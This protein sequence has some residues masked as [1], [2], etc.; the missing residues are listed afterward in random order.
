MSAR[1]TLLAAIHA[2]LPR[3]LTLADRAALSPNAGSADRGYWH[4]RVDKDYPSATFAQI[5]WPLALL[6]ERS[7]LGL[8]TAVRDRLRRVALDAISWW[9]VIQHRDGSF[10]EWFRFERSQVAT[11]FT[12]FAV[13]EAAWILREPLATWPNRARLF[14]ALARSCHWLA[15]HPDRAVANHAAGAVAAL[16]SVARLIPDSAIARSELDALLPLQTDEGWFPEYGGADPGYATVSLAFLA[17]AQRH[18]A[19][20]RLAASITKLADFCAPFV[21]P[22]GSFGGVYGRRA[23]RYAWLQGFALLAQKSPSARATL[24]RLLS[25]LAHG[26]LPAPK[27]FDDRYLCFFAFPDLVATLAAL[28][29]LAVPDATPPSPLVSLPN[30]GL[31]TFRSDD[32]HVVIGGRVGGAVACWNRHTGRLLY[33][34]SGYVGRTRDGKLVTSWRFPSEVTL[35]ENQATVSGDFAT[36]SRRS[37][38]ERHPVTFRVFNQTLGRVP[39]IAR[40]VT[41]FAK[42]RF[43]SRPR[44]IGLRLHRHVELRGEEL[45]ITDRITRDASFTLETLHHASGFAPI[46]VPSAPLWLPAFEPTQP[47]DSA[48]LVDAQPEATEWRVVTRVRM[49]QGGVPA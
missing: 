38:I 19:D 26:G 32:L 5:A 12:T 46:H 27:D 23:T 41:R 15:R 2:A 34:D 7:D 21:N 16:A 45:V 13:A 48:N 11:A 47:L 3:I 25:G 1:D 42:S 29:G 35:G 9:T 28:D 14:A 33:D 8:D 6:A 20:P 30:A 24:S 18:L 4:Y 40:A 36:W 44:P 39:T 17:H 31:A 10:D 49:D 43:T 37:P 22:D